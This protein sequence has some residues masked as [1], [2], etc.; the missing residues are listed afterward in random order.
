MPERLAQV[1][2]QRY[3]PWARWMTDPASLFQA[4][5]ACG[6]RCAGQRI[7]SCTHCGCIRRDQPHLP[8]VLSMAVFGAGLEQSAGVLPRG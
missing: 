3:L 6:R 4:C 1:Y 5:K 8:L 2:H 7:E